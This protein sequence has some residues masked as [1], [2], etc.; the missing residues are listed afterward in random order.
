MSCKPPEQPLLARQQLEQL[1]HVGPF[2]Q[3]HLPQPDIAQLHQQVVLFADQ[4]GRCRWEGMAKCQWVA[5][6]C[7]PLAGQDRPAG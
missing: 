1:R 7:D 5:L 6:G 3:L 2:D 4:F